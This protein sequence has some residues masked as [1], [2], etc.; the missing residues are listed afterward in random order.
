MIELIASKIVSML[1][2][3]ETSPMM[4][5][6]MARNLV[7]GTVHILKNRVTERGPCRPEL[8]LI[9]YHTQ[10][11]IALQQCVRGCV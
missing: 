3:E 4:A 7:D 11:C 1:A 2:D 5:Q 9:T 6:I 10:E 8:A